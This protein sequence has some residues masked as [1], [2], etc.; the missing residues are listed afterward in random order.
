MY[1]KLTIFQKGLLLFSIPLLLQALFV[2]ILVTTQSEV[3][4]AQRWAVHT[5]EVVAKVEQTY[6]GLLEDF[7]GMRNRVP[8]GD[9]SAVEPGSDNLDQTSRQIEEL[10]LLVSDNR[11]QQPRIRTLAQRSHQFLAWLMTQKKPSFSELSRQN[12]SQVDQGAGLL[13]EVRATVDEILGVEWLLDQDRME[14]LRQT[15]GRQLWILAGGGLSIL[16]TT[17]VLALGFFRD[18]VQRLSIVRDN[19]IRLADG[20][21]LKEPLWGQDEIAE[22]DRAFHE[23][24]SNLAQQRQENEM[25]V[26]SVSH[27]LRSPLINLQGFS[28]ELSLSYRDIQ[29]LFEDEN[30]PRPVRERGLDLLSENIEESIRFIQTA[31]GRLA[32]IIDA[33][34]RLS[35][36][37]RVEYQCQS[38][39]VAAIVQK[40]LE[41]LDGTIRAKKAEIVVGD[42]PPAWVDPTAVEQIFANLI[43]N[44]VQYLDPTRLGRI[45]VGCNNDLGPG[46]LAGLHVYFIKDNGLGIPEAYQ[47]RVFT[48]FNRLQTN[49][50]QGEGVGLTLVRRVVERLGGKIWLESAAGV[51]S[52]FFVALPSRPRADA[53]PAAGESSGTNLQPRG[54]STT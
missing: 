51:G 25:F 1:T 34:L 46:N 13:G 21:P 37:G 49:V 50:A 15:S 11:S 44:S 5:K 29:A 36:A 26:Y 3:V 33:L 54:E 22:V 42:L 19:A 6:R 28:E 30:V 45:E 53:R 12:G 18:V 16:A 7:S 9:R 48:P 10:R 47:Q 27:D 8:S 17:L 31:V 35:R 52:T 40:V 38:T 41:A 24:A 4:E 23:M 32:R 39:Q 2:G 14:V 43:G 20:G